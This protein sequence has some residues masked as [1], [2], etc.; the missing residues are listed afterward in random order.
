M[1]IAARYPCDCRILAAPS[2]RQGGCGIIAGR[3]RAN[4]ANGIDHTSS[5][6]RAGTPLLRLAA[7]IAFG[8]MLGACSK[9]DIPTPWQHS[10]AGD[11][12]AA[13]HKD[14]APQ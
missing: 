10:S 2:R 11:V 14:P 7:L 3:V 6:A 1:E 13:C 8:L 9:C 5:T 4:M 12:P